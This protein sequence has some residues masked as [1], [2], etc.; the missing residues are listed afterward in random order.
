MTALGSFDF[1]QKYPHYTPPTNPH[2]EADDFQHI[3][4]FLFLAEQITDAWLAARYGRN[5]RVRFRRVSEV[6]PDSVEVA[7]EDYDGN[8]FSLMLPRE[9]FNLSHVVPEG[10]T[11]ADS[12]RGKALAK[13]VEEIKAQEAAQLEA[14]LAAHEARLAEHTKRTEEETIARLRKTR[15]E[16]FKD[17]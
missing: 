3:A 16:L 1:A 17:A 5:N 12:E 8:S 10:G 9:W 15:P 11:Y 6:W 13:A 2:F 14:N 4:D 7:Y